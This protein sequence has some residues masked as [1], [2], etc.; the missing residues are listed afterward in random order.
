MLPDFQ[1]PASAATPREDDLERIVEV[2]RD[3]SRRRPLGGSPSGGRGAQAG[4]DAVA[5]PRL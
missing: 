1:V 4:R 3:G 5:A 2:K